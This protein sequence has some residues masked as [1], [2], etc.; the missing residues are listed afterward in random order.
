MRNEHFQPSSQ[1]FDLDIRKIKPEISVNRLP[2]TSFYQAG[3]HEIYHDEK[4]KKD[5]QDN[6][7]KEISES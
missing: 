2:K 4:P 6:S 7:S 3:L 5:E 1:E